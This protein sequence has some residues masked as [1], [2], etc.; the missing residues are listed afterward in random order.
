MG[1]QHCFGRFVAVALG[2]IL[3]MTLCVHAQAQSMP[4]PSSS[5]PF[6]VG[7]NISLQDYRQQVTMNL[8]D[9]ARG[10]ASPGNGGD[11]TRH[12]APLDARGLPTATADIIVTNPD[13]R[14]SFPAGLYRGTHT[15]TAKPSIVNGSGWVLSNVRRQGDRWTYDLHAKGNGMLWMR[16]DGTVTS[17]PSI[18]PDGVDIDRAPLLRPEVIAN[19]SRY[20]KLRF[21]GFAQPDG[22][23]PDEPTWAHR[24]TPEAIVAGRKAWE[25]QFA[26]AAELHKA[27]GSRVQEVWIN[28][29]D[30]ADA[31]YVLRLAELA[32]KMLPPT[33]ILGVSGANEG[34]WNW[35]YP[36]TSRLHADSKDPKHP[37]YQRIG[38]DRADQWDRFAR[39]YGLRH[40]RIAKAFKA[41]MGSQVRPVMEGHDL[42]VHW[43]RDRMLPWLQQP[44]QVAEFGSFA[45]YTHYLSIGGYVDGTP[46]QYAAAADGAA[47]VSCFRSGCKYSLDEPKKVNGW[48]DWVA[49]ARAHRIASVYLYEWGPHTWGN[50]VVAKKAAA[51]RHPSMR[52]LILDMAR[53]FKSLGID[54]GHFYSI[55]ASKWVDNNVHSLWS[56][57][58]AY[59]VPTPKSQ[60]LDTL[61]GGS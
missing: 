37:D 9:Q 14:L 24:V 31:E 7:G 27:P 20:P 58:E 21:M 28:L 50:D 40:A 6:V 61:L 42:Q 60:A 17:R 35:I 43:V 44:E 19:W 10:W 59:D 56:A 53:T 45:S 36:Q 4:T 23:A 15:G 51:H 11:P 57:Q 2:G 39:L 8:M 34:G 22:A 54:G 18:L 1:S 46:E 5:H 30:R 32:K 12:P 38:G 49:V 26:A 3:G 52:E 55:H 29:P 48:K 33:L 13:Y 25:W 16:F 41:V 47:I